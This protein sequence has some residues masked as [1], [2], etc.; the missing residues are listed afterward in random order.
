MITLSRK[1]LSIIPV[2]SGKIEPVIK[3]EDNFQIVDKERKQLEKSGPQNYSITPNFPIYD[4]SLAIFNKGR[5]VI[6]TERR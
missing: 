1:V 4:T 3:K 6:I 5:I 2:Q